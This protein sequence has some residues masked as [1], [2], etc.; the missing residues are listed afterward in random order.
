MKNPAPMLDPN[1]SPEERA[2]LWASLS[3]RQRL[4]L[5]KAGQRAAMPSSAARQAAVQAQR[6]DLKV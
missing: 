1:A 5:L 6:D 3:K 2:A 4:A